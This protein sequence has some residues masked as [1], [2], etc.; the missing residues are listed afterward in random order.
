MK[1]FIDQKLQQA[2]P[3]YVE[4]KVEQIKLGSDTTSV[5]R[6]FSGIDHQKDFDAIVEVN[7][8]SQD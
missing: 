6:P 8:K 5:K 3:G 2:I 4:P 1:Q 7:E